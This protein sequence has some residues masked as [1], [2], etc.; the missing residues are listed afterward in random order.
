MPRV[1]PLV[2]VAIVATLIATLGAAATQEQA[3]RFKGGVNV[4]QLDVAVLDRDGRPIQGLTA[5][6]FTVLE[7][8]RPQRIAALNE[9]VIP[10]FSAPATGWLREVAPDVRHNQLPDGRVMVIVIDDGMLPSDPAMVR[11]TKEIA[12]GIVDRMGPGDLASVVFTRDGRNAQAFTSDRERLLRAIDRTTSGFIFNS[13]RD[14]PVNTD[15]HYYAATVETL[16]MVTEALRNVPNRRKTV[17]YVG[18][19][20]AFD[21]GANAPRLIAP[22]QSM[23]GQD[24]QQALQDSTR[25]LFQQ[26]VSGQTAIYTFDP[27]GLD[28]LEGYAAT[29]PDIFIPPPSQF[30]DALHILANNTGGRATLETNDWAPGLERMFRETSAYYLLGYE[31]DNLKTDGKFRRLSIEV[32]RSG[33]QVQARNGYYGPEPERA[34]ARKE[35]GPSVATAIAQVLPQAGLPMQAMAVPFAGTGRKATVAI[36]AGLRHE[37]AATATEESVELQVSA[38]DLDGRPKGSQRQTA[39]LRLR[40]VSDGEARYEILTKLEI[41]PGRYMLRLGAQSLTAGHVGSVHLDVDVPDFSREALSASGVILTSPSAPM[42][43]P[44]EALTNLIPITPTTLRRFTRKQQV[45]G[46]L[47]LYQGGKKTLVPVAAS[48]RIVDARDTTVWRRTIEVGADRFNSRA[49][50]LKFD[51]PIADLVPGRY[52]IDVGIE[53]EGSRQPLNRRV[54]ITIDQ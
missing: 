35:S 44:P 27:S 11:Y 49:A 19:G 23:S 9:V 17:A 43:A 13:T 45:S 7:D 4:I 36:V 18:I 47:R 26:S 54:R 40:P 48:I 42:S 5:N 32:N 39:R 6:D 53:A 20:V 12:T 50:D 25:Q 41:D 37:V 15:G 21:P 31:S 30:R 29:R 34:R 33:A 46:F 52:L 3:P 14:M 51:V 22:G 10:A 8:G 38:F 16:R 28:G 1:S 2:A 24:L